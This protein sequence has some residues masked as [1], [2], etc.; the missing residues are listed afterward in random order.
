MTVRKSLLAATTLMTAVA[1]APAGDAEDPV[2][3]RL[4]V[5]IKRDSAL[6]ILGEGAAPTDSIPNVQR[7]EAY[8]V[9]GQP[10]EILFWS[11]VGVQNPAPAESTLRPVVLSGDMVIGWGWKFFDS[12]ATVH[13]I[14][15]KPRG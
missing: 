12:V 13:D 6:K 9:Q 2:L 4:A 15:V 3:S 1:C 14:R 11:P 7:R 10:L 8:L 5:G